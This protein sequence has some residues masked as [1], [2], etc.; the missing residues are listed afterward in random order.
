MIC[1]NSEVRYLVDHEWAL[2][3]EDIL[4]RRSRLGLVIDDEGKKAL[5]GWLDDNLKKAA[6]ES[7]GDNA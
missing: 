4:W 2:T 1:M 3:A 6:N 7:D 5:Q